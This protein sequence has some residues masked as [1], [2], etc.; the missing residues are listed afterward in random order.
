MSWVVG[1]LGKETVEVLKVEVLKHF[2]FASLIRIDLDSLRE[3][4]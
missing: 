3:L 4:V 2:V 1:W